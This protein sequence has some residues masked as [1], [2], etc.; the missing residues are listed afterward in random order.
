MNKKYQK[1]LLDNKW[2]EKR[3]KIYERD[4]FQCK[5]CNKSNLKLN[6]HH[7]I[8]FKNCNPWDYED[9]FLITLCENCHNNIHKTIKIKTI[10]PNQKNISEI[11]KK[12]KLEKYKMY[13]QKIKNKTTQ[14]AT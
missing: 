4:N 3:K 11:K 1:L 14:I 13:I 9:R 2:I 8:Y 10:K 12:K 5:K 7:K 6:V